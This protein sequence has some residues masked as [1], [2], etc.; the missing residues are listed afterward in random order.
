MRIE[1]H[2]PEL[3]PSSPSRNWTVVST[4]SALQV[5]LKNVPERFQAHLLP[6]FPCRLPNGLIVATALVHDLAI[7]TRNVKD[8]AETGAAIIDPW[9]A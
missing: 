6:G 1:I 8:F 4:R 2:K 3:S 7:T 5:S 9:G